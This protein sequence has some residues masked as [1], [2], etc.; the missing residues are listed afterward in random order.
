MFFIFDYLETIN[1]TVKQSRSDKQLT[2]C[3]FLTYKF[4]KVFFYNCPRCEVI[5]I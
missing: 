1:S 5:E 2:L 4:K 3:F